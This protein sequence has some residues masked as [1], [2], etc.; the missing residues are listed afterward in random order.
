MELN[1]VI[2][3]IIYWRERNWKGEASLQVHNMYLRKREQEKCEALQLVYA[4]ALRY[5]TGKYDPEKSHAF[6]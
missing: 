1:L 6:L 4:V 2:I 5:I 3:T